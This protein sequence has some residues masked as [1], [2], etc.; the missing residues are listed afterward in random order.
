MTEEVQLGHVGP[1]P[2]A[3]VRR[4]AALAELSRVVPETIGDV[5]TYHRTVRPLPQPGHNVAVYSNCVNGEV[6][7]EGGCEVAEPFD[8]DGRV[9]CSAIPG[10]LVASLLHVGP[11]SAL[12]DA[13]TA[14][15]RWCR[16]QGYQ[17]AGPSWEV[18]GHERGDGSPPQTLVC[19]LLREKEE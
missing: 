8:G 19:Y 6:D 1:R 10:G 15:G 17:F 9:V 5:W 2:I 18:Y 16:E 3:V 12:G 11:Y 14:V 7:L 13:H 4:R